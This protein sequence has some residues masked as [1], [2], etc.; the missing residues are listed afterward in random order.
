M[1]C[2]GAQLPTSTTSKALSMRGCRRCLSTQMIR[3]RCLAPLCGVP[4]L[5][6]D[7]DSRFLSGTYDL[8]GETS[9]RSISD[10]IW[11][12]LRNRQASQFDSY[13]DMRCAANDIGCLPCHETG[14]RS[15]DVNESQ[16]QAWS[17]ND[18]FFRAAA[19]LFQERERV[20]TVRAERLAVLC[21]V[22]AMPFYE[23]VRRVT[24]LQSEPKAATAAA[25]D[26]QR[27]SPLS[28]ENWSSH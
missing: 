14:Q 15:R 11:Y 9:S 21:R 12:R 28:V 3:E 18:F 6:R 1:P 22:A 4:E 13:A 16:L 27:S 24:T 10:G 2:G 19:L 17:R 26:T 25:R 23:A 20:T 8:P 5:A 7:F